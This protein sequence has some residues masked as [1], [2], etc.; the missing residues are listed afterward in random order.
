MWLCLAIGVGN[1]DNFRKTPKGSA[2]NVIYFVVCLKFY[3]VI[4][5]VSATK[6]QIAV[7]KVER[8]RQ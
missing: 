6:F 2:A 4:L 7:K 8:K 1:K 5:V 3:L